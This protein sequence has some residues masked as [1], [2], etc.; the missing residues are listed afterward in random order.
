ML[1]RRR[2]RRIPE[3]QMSGQGASRGRQVEQTH[4]TGANV[5]GLVGE[6]DLDRDKATEPPHGHEGRGCDDELP[7]VRG[8]G[9]IL[10]RRCTRREPLDG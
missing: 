7:G 8:V 1:V 6:A 10:H 4:T 9:Q 5:P 2:S 3:N